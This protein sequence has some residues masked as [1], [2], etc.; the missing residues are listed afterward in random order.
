[1]KNMKIS[2]KLLTGFF[3]TSVIATIIGFVGIFGMWQMHMSTN[4]LYEIQTKPLATMTRVINSITAMRVQLRGAVIY[5]DDS[6][7]VEEALAEFNKLDAEVTAAI[8]EYEP[9]ITGA[10]SLALFKESQSLYN[11]TFKPGTLKVFD[12]AKKGNFEDTRKAMSEMTEA[13]N[14]MI[15][16]FY[17]CLDNRI[18]NAAK[19]AETNM[20]LFYTLSGILVAVI[21]G[22]FVSSILLGGYISGLISNPIKKIVEAANEISLGNADIHVDIYSRDE[23]G[24]LADAFNRMADG[25][26]QQVKVVA[27]VAEG[28]LTVNV[29]VRSDKDTMGL[30]LKETCQKLSRMF[31]EISEAADQVSTGSEQ[32][33]ISAQSLSQGATEQASSVEEL[34]AS[35]LNVSGQVNENTDSIALAAK[36]VNEATEGIIKSSSYMENMLSAMNEINNSSAEI[37]KIIKVIDD[38][39]FQ[40]NI[41]ALNAAVEAA[42]AGS[43]GK[44][45]AVVADEV[46]NLA[47]KSA[48]AAKQT[49]ALID[50]SIRSVD[51][52]AK[53]AEETAA[54]LAEAREKAAIVAQ[55]MDKVSKASIEQ[56]EAI[57]QINSG[58]EQIST[59]VQTNSATAEESAAASEELSGQANTLKQL[60]A[61]FKFNEIHSG[62]NQNAPSKII[63]LDFN[64]NFPTASNFE[65]A[66]EKY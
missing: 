25:I 63:N 17:Q 58:V 2:K 11:N 27:A 14:Q 44:G 1:M 42:R 55:A 22:G 3:I 62:P 53:I 35:L 56:A 24:E 47:S 48:E 10:S 21:I 45:F 30:A 66:G 36:A 12:V 19:T 13:T 34:S 57:N 15:S 43:A 8:K 4:K 33:S 52:G 9:T 18:N 37:S 41:L 40:T 64:E 49:T 50:H 5:A 60:I 46:R 7:K 28:D 23:T 31:S 61:V 6:K 59:V 16:N 32:V 39:A 29:P 65:F 26:K 20:I 51:N 38:I 54:S